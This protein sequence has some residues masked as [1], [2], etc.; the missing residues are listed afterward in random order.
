MTAAVDPN[1]QRVL[2]A[3]AETT[4][5]YLAPP[6]VRAAYVAEVERRIVDAAEA[7]ARA[8][9]KREA[10][11][12]ARA[13]ALKPPIEVTVM[14][15]STGAKSWTYFDGSMRREALTLE[16]L[17]EHLRHREAIAARTR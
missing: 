7:P 17:E 13:K 14:R 8:E 1:L 10:E 4:A 2:R 12:I 15:G 11:L 16:S 6:G 5:E 9:A 3:F